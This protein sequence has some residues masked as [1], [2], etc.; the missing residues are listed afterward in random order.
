MKSN[1]KVNVFELSAARFS[2]DFLRNLEQPIETYRDDIQ[3]IFGLG[4]VY[5]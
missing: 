3:T 1:T 2:G 4:F 5:G